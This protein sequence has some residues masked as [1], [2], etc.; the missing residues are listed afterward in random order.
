MAKAKVNYIKNCVEEYLGSPLIND[1]FQKAYEISQRKVVSNME[2]RIR[3]IVK[4]V[5]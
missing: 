1:E 5:K 2:D 4:C 3:E